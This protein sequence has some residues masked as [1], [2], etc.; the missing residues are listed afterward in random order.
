MTSR[1]VKQKNQTISKKMFTDCQQAIKYLQ[2]H[3]V[4]TINKWIL[5]YYYLLSTVFSKLKFL[6]NLCSLFQVFHNLLFVSVLPSCEWTEYTVVVKYSLTRRS[7]WNLLWRETLTNRKTKSE[8][9][10]LKL[11]WGVLNR[12]MEDD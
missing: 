1:L 11:F 6:W 5:N 2:T 3:N 4:I 12:K 9:E 8:K 7:G 10:E